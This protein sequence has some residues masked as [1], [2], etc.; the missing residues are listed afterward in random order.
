MNIQKR[1][2]RPRP[3]EV[4]KQVNVDKDGFI[5]NFNQTLY[6]INLVSEEDMFNRLLIACDFLKFVLNT[7][8]YR[9]CMHF[10]LA[11]KLIV[12][13][14]GSKRSYILTRIL[15][16]RNLI[17]CSTINQQNVD[18]LLLS[19]NL[20]E[21]K[22]K[23]QINE[24][25]ANYKRIKSFNNFKPRDIYPTHPDEKWPSLSEEPPSNIK[26]VNYSYKPKCQTKERAFTPERNRDT[27]SYTNH[28]NKHIEKIPLNELRWRIATKDI[29]GL[30]IGNYEKHLSDEDFLEA[31]G[32][33]KEDF[34]KL[35]KWK[36]TNIKNKAN[37]F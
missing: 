36:Q 4:T 26:N 19:L 21:N 13:M 31:L 2:F 11:S 35:P 37:L 7:D 12:S 20:K 30:Y 18:N 27:A 32:I 34:N 6:K 23:E 9:M 28:S 24:M 14:N 22:L 8:K 25:F 17:D 16:S 5:H 10:D 33:N 15:L 1:V 3:V 29:D